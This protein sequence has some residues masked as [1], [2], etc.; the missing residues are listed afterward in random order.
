MNLDLKK[1]AKTINKYLSNHL[2]DLRHEQHLTMRGVAEIINT[3]HS[4]VGKIEQQSRRMDVGEFVIYCR[5]IK[6]NPTAVL[7]QL[8]ETYSQSDA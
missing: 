1:E 7:E 2:R 3:P 8:I 6:Q 5:A 4:F